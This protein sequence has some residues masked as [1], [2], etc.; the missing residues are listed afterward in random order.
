MNRGSERLLAERWDLAFKH[1]S[2]LHILDVYI[3]G[4][5]YRSRWGIYHPGAIT[6]PTF[7]YVTLLIIGTWWNFGAKH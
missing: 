7:P 4:G 2:I 3:E 6:L 5:K 1:S